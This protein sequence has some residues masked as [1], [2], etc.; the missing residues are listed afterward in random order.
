MTNS[1]KIKMLLAYLDISQAELARK[2]DTTPQAL[3]QRLKNDKFTYQE[4]E[5]IAAVLG[6]TWS[7]SFILSDGTKI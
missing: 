3:G 5:K 1:G 4:M 2:L 7:A 6:A